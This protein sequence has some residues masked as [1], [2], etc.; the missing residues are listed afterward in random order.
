MS[1]YPVLFHTAINARD[2]RGLADWL[3]LLDSNGNRV[4]T[5]Q[6]KKNTARTPSRWALDCSMTVHRTRANRSTCLHTQQGI[7][8]VCSF[9]DRTGDDALICRAL[10]LRSPRD[11]PLRPATSARSGPSSPRGQHHRRGHR[12]HAGAPEPVA[13]PRTVDRLALGQRLEDV[14]VVGV[15]AIT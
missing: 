8:S 6:E 15:H 4:L 1:G 7:R 3:V 11:T 2:C 9:S 10:R 12:H 5:I 14:A 13:A